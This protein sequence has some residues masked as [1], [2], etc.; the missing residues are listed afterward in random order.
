MIH[1]HV[2]DDEDED[3]DDDDYELTAMLRGPASVPA[4]DRVIQA[5]G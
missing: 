3:E 4:N 5:K 2:S 1:P